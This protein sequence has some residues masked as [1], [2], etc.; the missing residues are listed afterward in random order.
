MLMYKYI[1]RHF[2]WFNRK[3]RSVSRGITTEVHVHIDKYFAWFNHKYISVSRSIATE[4][5]V[6]INKALCLV[7]L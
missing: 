4:V 1:D 2:T 7:Q 3:Y 5:H 6:D